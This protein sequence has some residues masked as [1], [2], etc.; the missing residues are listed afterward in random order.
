MLKLNLILAL[1]CSALASL[2]FATYP[3]APLSA[4]EQ[5]APT[6][7]E[8]LGDTTEDSGILRVSLYCGHCLMVINEAYANPPKG[9][10]PPRIIL[11]SYGEDDKLTP[12]FLSAIRHSYGDTE[13][14]KFLVPFT[15][16]MQAFQNGQ[17]FG[18]TMQRLRQLHP[19]ISE[20]DPVILAQ[21]SRQVALLKG[22][23]DRGTPAY[24]ES[25]TAIPSQASP[26]TIFQ[27]QPAAPL[28]IPAPPAPISL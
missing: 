28:P 20:T 12:I 16:V 6:Y 10:I 21:I 18:V 24:Y 17:T 2:S 22:M 9:G 14:D 4:I 3:A 25:L 19:E 5:T 1:A 26:A 15:L 7:C 13:Q 8:W 11:N 23:Q 27:L